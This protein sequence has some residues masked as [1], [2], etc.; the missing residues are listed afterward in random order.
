ME[1]LLREAIRI[2]KPGIQSID[3]QSLIDQWDRTLARQLRHSQQQFSEHH[4]ANG[5]SAKEM[6]S[7]VSNIKTPSRTQ[8]TVDVQRKHL[9]SKTYK[10]ITASKLKSRITNLKTINKRKK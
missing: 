7:A 4:P 1:W 10:K 6:Q 8:F 2:F 9:K 3:E 5:T